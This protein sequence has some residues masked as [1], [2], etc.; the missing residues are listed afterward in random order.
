LGSW[1]FVVGY[2]FFN[3]SKSVRIRELPRHPNW[4][5]FWE[6]AKKMHPRDRLGMKSITKDGKEALF[7]N[8]S[9]HEEFGV[10]L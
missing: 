2:P 10:R 4:D 8:H 3:G 6:K 5:R 1:K 9:N 7:F